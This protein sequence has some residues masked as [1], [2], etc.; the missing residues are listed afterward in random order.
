MKDLA[1]ALWALGLGAG[2]I[3]AGARRAVDGA[4]DSPLQEF[5][6]NQGSSGQAEELSLPPGCTPT[7]CTVSVS[8]CTLLWDYSIKVCLP[9]GTGL[10]IGVRGHPRGLRAQQQV[11]RRR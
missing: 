5:S 4:P 10:S 1:L 2:G 6:K 9:H 7:C 3:R 8:N 11:L